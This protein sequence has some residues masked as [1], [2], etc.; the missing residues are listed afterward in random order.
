MSKDLDSIDDQEATTEQVGDALKEWLTA[1]GKELAPADDDG[2]TAT[3]GQ[4]P[5][6]EGH[7]ESQDGPVEPAPQDDKADSPEAAEEPENASQEDASKEDTLQQKYAALEAKL[8][9]LEAREAARIEAE[10]KTNA[11]NAA[12]IKGN[13]S[14]LLTGS[15]DT[16]NAQIDLLKQFAAQNAPA[17]SLPRDPAVDADLFAED[18]E[19]TADE[20]LRGHSDV[21]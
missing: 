7:Q 16:W 1:G 8:A 4:E 18:K 6:Q 9:E 10:Q 19:L 13:Y 3:D 12:G 2:D 11:L 17:V 20:F 5:Q 21:I 15:P 14:Q